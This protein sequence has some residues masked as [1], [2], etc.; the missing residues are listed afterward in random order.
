VVLVTLETFPNITN[1]LLLVAVVS[2]GICDIVCEEAVYQLNG[3]EA[4][5]KL[6]KGVVVLTPENATIAPVD[7]VED[8]VTANT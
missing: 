5:V 8:V 6:S 3:N 4:K 2:D 1:A 7:A